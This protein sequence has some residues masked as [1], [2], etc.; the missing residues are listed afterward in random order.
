MIVCGYN[1]HHLDALYIVRYISVS[2]CGRR[3]LTHSTTAW[4]CSV[5]HNHMR[6]F[7]GMN[8]AAGKLIKKMT[9]SLY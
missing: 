5:N 8:G 9:F 6:V 2:L 4:D 3:P 7:A 1:C